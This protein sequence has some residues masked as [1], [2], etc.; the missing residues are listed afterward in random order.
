MLAPILDRVL[1]F[2]LGS[3]GRMIVELIQNNKWFFLSMFLIYGGIILYAKVIWSHYM[4]KKMYSYLKST[5]LKN[6]SIEEL[7]QGWLR[8]RKNLPQYIL[9]P[10]HNEFWVKP[11]AKMTGT[12]QKLFYNSNRKKMNEK[13]CFTLIAEQ[14]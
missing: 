12:E 9:V 14:L 8:Y 1:Y 13:D 6:R 10:T 7:Y 11:A 5:E 3:F 2:N 4:P